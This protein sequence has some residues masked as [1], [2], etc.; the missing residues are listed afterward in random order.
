MR[1]I[2]T[3]SSNSSVA[4]LLCLVLVGSSPAEEG[5]PLAKRQKKETATEDTPVQLSM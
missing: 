5:T 4:H 1:D 2:Y 3:G